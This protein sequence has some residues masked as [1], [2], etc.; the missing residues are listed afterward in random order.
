MVQYDVLTVAEA[1]EPA[2]RPHEARM[3]LNVMLHWYAV[4]LGGTLPFWLKLGF[5]GGLYWRV[6]FCSVTI[7][8]C[9]RSCVQRLLIAVMHWALQRGGASSSEQ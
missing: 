5:K 9:V 1:G 8:D 6:Q 2:S 7:C 4:G 3:L